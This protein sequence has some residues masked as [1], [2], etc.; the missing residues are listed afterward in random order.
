MNSP[1]SAYKETSIKTASQGRLIVMLYEEAVRQ[2]EL[3]AD[4]IK[5][6][7]KARF[8]D[9]NKSI[10]KAQ[11]IISELMSSLDMQA[12][13]EIASNLMNLYIYFNKTLLE[14]NMEKNADKILQVSRFM[15]DLRGAWATIENS[16]PTERAVPRTAI[17][18]AG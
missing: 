3:A 2:M 15:D 8:D 17:N 13:G 12:G 9:V 16:V 10:T 7:G 11:A 5:N 4:L 18:I 14:G 1:L 6:E